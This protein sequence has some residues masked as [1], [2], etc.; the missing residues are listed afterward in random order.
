[1]S[2]THLFPAIP[3]SVASVALFASSGL[4]FGLSQDEMPTSYP[5]EEP[6]PAEMVE[7]IQDDSAKR[8]NLT[9]LVNA[10]LDDY[11]PCAD[12]P[13]PA[14]CRC[15]LEFPPVAFD[16]SLDFVLETNPV[17]GAY[18]LATGRT[19]MNFVRAI[20]VAAAPPAPAPGAP[21]I[22]LHANP[23]PTPDGRRELELVLARNPNF[24]E[25]ELISVIDMPRHLGGEPDRLFGGIWWIE[26]MR[27]LVIAYRGTQT[28]FEWYLDQQVDRYHQA[29][30]TLSV[31]KG[32]GL[33]YEFC[34]EEVLV[35]IDAYQPAHIFVAGHSL[36]GAVAAITAVDLQARLVRTMNNAR[37]HGMTFG[38]P[39]TFAPDATERIDSAIEAGDLELWRVVNQPDPVPNVPPAATSG[40]GTK[41]QHTG[42]VVFYDQNAA[43]EPGRSAAWNHHFYFEGY[44]EAW[45]GLV[46]GPVA[47]TDPESGSDDASGAADSVDSADT[48]TPAD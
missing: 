30:P 33:G 13:V 3:L 2:S 1:M 46:R 24:A 26:S 14:I 47:A 43:S 39:R 20:V 4:A 18:D 41:Y 12:S 15:A 22:L 31:A 32:F 23:S 28:P 16:A 44:F 21:D 7:T 37:V 25:A 19:L 45:P 17:D 9:R 11:D 38:Q 42:R 36:G 8:E 5:P 35:A 10:V 27:S 48:V 40:T 34:R 6:A 29:R